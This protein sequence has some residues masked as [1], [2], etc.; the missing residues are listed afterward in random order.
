MTPVIKVM[1]E[2]EVSISASTLDSDAAIER[3]L[4]LATAYL[5]SEQRR[6]FLEAEALRNN[7]I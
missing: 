1:N 4:A 2:F 3:K 5:I 6:L 7:T